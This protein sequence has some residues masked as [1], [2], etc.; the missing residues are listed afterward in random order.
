MFSAFESVADG[1]P[2]IRVFEAACPIGD[3]R[4]RA[5]RI[6]P[7]PRNDDLVRIR[8]DHEDC[9]MRSRGGASPTS[10]GF[11]S[12]HGAPDDC[13]RRFQMQLLIAAADISRFDAA[14]FPSSEIRQ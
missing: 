14:L 5:V 9:V 10:A 8:V 7:G 2:D 12:G 6:G 3:R 11:A 1:F 13:G 4:Q